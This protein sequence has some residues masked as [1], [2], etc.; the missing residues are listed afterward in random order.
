MLPICPWVWATSQWP[1]HQRKATLSLSGHQLPTAPLGSTEPWGSPHHPSA[2][3]F[4]LAWSYAGIDTGYCQSKLDNR[5]LLLKIPLICMQE[6]EKL[7]LSLTRELS[8]CWPSYILPGRFL[9]M[10]ICVQKSV[11]AVHFFFFFPGR[12]SRW[13]GAHWLG[14]LAGCSVRPKIHLSPHPEHWDFKY[15]ATKPGFLKLMWVLGIE[16]R[17]SCLQGEGFTDCAISRPSPYLLKI[18]PHVLS[19]PWK[20]YLCIIDTVLWGQWSRQ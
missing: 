12:V 13:P 14:R 8:P 20:W 3:E 2:L 6:T 9:Y 18:I 19:S 15:T 7:T 16:L 5:T 17:S 10:C 11:E 1:Y 4:W